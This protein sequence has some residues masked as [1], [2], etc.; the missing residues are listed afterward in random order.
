MNIFGLVL[1]ENKFWFWSKN[2]W[3]NCFVEHDF[4]VLVETA[5][6]LGRQKFLAFAFVLVLVEKSFWF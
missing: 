3:L 5:C 4:L 6:G 2:N 1:D